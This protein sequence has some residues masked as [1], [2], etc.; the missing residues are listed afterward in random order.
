M[1]ISSVPVKTNELIGLGRNTRKYF[2]EKSGSTICFIS[3]INDKICMYANSVIPIDVLDA[4]LQD[5]KKYFRI[6]A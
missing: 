4:I 6:T 3:V 5:H 2:C 1:Q